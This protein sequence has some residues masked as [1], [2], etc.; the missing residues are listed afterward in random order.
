MVYV[1]LN[2]SKYKKGTE[3]YN[4]KEKN[5]YTYMEHLLGINI[6]GLEFLWWV[7]E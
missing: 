4:I 3:K 6:A 5:V 2:M 7:N 1:Y